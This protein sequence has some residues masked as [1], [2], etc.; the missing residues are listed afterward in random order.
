MVREELAS[1]T[2]LPTPLANKS[3]LFSNFSEENG[4]I[5]RKGKIC[6][7]SAQE[8]RKKVMHDNHDVPCAGHRGIDKTIQL[9]RR[10]FWWPGLARDFHKYVQQCFQCQVNKAER[11]ANWKSISMDFIV[12]LPRTNKKRI[13]SL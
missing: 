6:V 7:P 10:T 13:L 11:E 3:S 9:V 8:L 1:S 12:G 5:K 4:F 2:S